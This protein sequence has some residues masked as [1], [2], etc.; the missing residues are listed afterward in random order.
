MVDAVEYARLETFGV[1]A[2]E[3]CSLT[4]AEDMWDLL[5]AISI[6]TPED[7]LTMVRRQVLEAIGSEECDAE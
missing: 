3:I 5:V 2:N 7:R 1:S 4:W 6:V